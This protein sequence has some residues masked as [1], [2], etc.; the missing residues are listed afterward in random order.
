MIILQITQ[1]KNFMNTLL[2][3]ETFDRF[4]VLRGVDHN[5][6]D[7][8]HRRSLHTDF[9]DPDDAQLLKEKGRTRLLWKDVKSFC[10]SVIKG[11]RTP[12]QFKFVF[13]LPQAACEKMIATCAA[14][15]K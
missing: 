9:F 8:L 3:L 13:Q 2:R 15:G 1:L 4:P 12:L 5:V 11:K 14:A 10:Y 6:Y 7:V